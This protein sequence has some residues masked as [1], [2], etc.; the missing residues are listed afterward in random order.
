[1]DG[2]LTALVKSGYAGQNEI[3]EAWK[4]IQIEF[5]DTIGN[6]E[7]VMYRNCIKEITVLNISLGA[8]SAMVDVLRKVYSKGIAER[9]N[10]ALGIKFDFDHTKPEQ[11][12]KLLDGCVNRSKSIKIKIDLLEI[13][14]K[15]MH[16]K[17]NQGEK[18]SREYYQ[19]ILITLSDHAKYQVND[20]ITVFEFCDRI[21]RF[22]KFSEQE[23]K[24][25]K[26]GRRE[27]R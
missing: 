4:Q 20:T 25:L 26:N 1:V 23:K 19:S 12:Q 8:I 16:K 6:H 21:K 2:N 9:L 18:T 10:K 27:N 13:Q 11:Y 5:A 14:Q 17:H 15:G 24:R 22:N 7:Y 3:I